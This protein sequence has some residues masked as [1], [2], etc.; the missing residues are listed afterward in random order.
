MPGIERLN[1]KSEE[2]TQLPK[3]PGIISCFKKQTKTYHSLQIQSHLSYPGSHFRHHTSKY[4]EYNAHYGRQI[5]LKGI[6]VL[7]QQMYRLG[8]EKKCR[9]LAIISSLS[10]TLK[11]KRSAHFPCDCI[12]T[13]FFLVVGSHLCYLNQ[14]QPYLFS[15]QTDGCFDLQNIPSFFTPI[16]D[17]FKIANA[18]SIQD[19]CQK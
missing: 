14:F 17:G 7:G 12:T 5:Y 10:L 2:L 8:Q 6:E 9:K 18:N 16:E 11:K 3:F 15:P 4:Q 19:M 1:R 13:E